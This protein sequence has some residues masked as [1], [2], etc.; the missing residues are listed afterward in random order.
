MIKN[1]ALECLN[2]CETEVLFKV[3]FEDG[4]IEYHCP[5]CLANIIKEVPEIIVSIIKEGGQ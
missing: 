5:G 1:M 3:S 4:A 2:G